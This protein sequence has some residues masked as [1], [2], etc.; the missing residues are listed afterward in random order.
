MAKDKA[1]KK[2]AAKKKVGKKKTAVTKKTAPKKV[3][4][5]K[6]VKKAAPKK[7]TSKSMQVADKHKEMQVIDPGTRQIMVAEAAYYHWEKSGFTGGMELEHWL[8]AEQEIDEK[9]KK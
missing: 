1:A 2:K 5:K 4:R 9:T 6:A 7:S 8:K 3:A